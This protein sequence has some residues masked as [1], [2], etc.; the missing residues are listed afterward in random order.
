MIASPRLRDGTTVWICR[1]ERRAG[2]C[3]LPCERFRICGVSGSG[4]KPSLLQTALP[5]SQ[6]NRTHFAESLATLRSMSSGQAARPACRPPARTRR[7]AG[8]LRQNS[9]TGGGSRIALHKSARR[10]RATLTVALAS[11]CTSEP[12]GISDESG[13]D[14]SPIPRLPQSRL[15]LRHA[16]RIAL[17][18]R[19]SGRRWACLCRSSRRCRP[20][21]PACCR[22]RPDGAAGRSGRRASRRRHPHGRVDRQHADR[23]Q[24]GALYTAAGGEPRL[25]VAGGHAQQ[26]RGSDSR[27]ACSTNSTAPISWAGAT[28][29]LPGGPRRKRH[30]VVPLV[31]DFDALRAAAASG[32]GIALLSSFRVVGLDV[33]AAKLVRQGSAVSHGTTPRQHLPAAGPAAAERARVRAFTEALRASIGSPPSWEP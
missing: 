18:S 6:R 9:C 15:R 27:I 21:I 24:A 23:D 7:P 5:G 8:W 12:C 11:A 32:L 4:D 16:F 33:R 17:A 20:T 28:C 13:A 25:S 1:D 14:T 30:G 2:D 31:D 19:P 22:A 29:R 3:A 26:R 10:G